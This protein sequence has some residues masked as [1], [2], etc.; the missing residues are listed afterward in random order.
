MLKRMRRSA[1]VVVVLGFVAV[2]PA[3][4]ACEADGMQLQILGSG[5]PGASAGRASAGYLVW[6]DGVGR[7]L[8]DAGGGIKQRFH[9]SGAD[10]GDVALLALSHLH[11]DHAAAVPALLWPRGA[12]LR[13]AGPSG[14]GLFPSLDDWLTGLFGPQGVFRVLGG[15]LELD[16]ITVDVTAGEAVEVWRDGGLRVTGIGVPHGGVPA[17]GYRV[18]AEGASVAF[19]SDQNGSD[20]AFIEFVRNVDVLVVHLGRAE[21]S[22]GRSA[23]LHA[24]PSGWGA[25]A[26]E[27][28]V[29]RVVASHIST[30]SPDV[31]ADSLR[32]LREFY[33]GPVTLAEDLLCVAV[34]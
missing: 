8:V 4:A 17:V 15:R 20:P 24:S 33:G 3:L 31:L 1:V 29:G 14:S 16:P 10:L 5:G 27:A 25:L 9:A 12:T 26:A 2:K 18:D 6:I 21:G 28:G 13:V 34:P 32:Y 30:S 7:I 22:T 23:E 19:S 11:P